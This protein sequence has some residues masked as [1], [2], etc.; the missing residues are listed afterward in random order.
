VTAVTLS[1]RYA[2]GHDIGPRP[3]PR[4][5]RARA[6]PFW[7]DDPARPEP[8][9]PLR[10]EVRADLAIVGGGLAGL[11]AALEALERDPGRDVV[12]LEGGVVGIGASGRTVGS[13][14]PP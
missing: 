1:G 4:A 9:D 6:V 7:L 14:R 8:T 10:G 12:L 5:R 13:A 3:A 2:G 11:W